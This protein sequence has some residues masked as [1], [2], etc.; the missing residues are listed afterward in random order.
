MSIMITGCAGFIG[1][2]AT[3]EFLSAGYDVIGVDSMTYAGKVENMS[4]FLSDISFFKDDICDTGR[5]KDIICSYDITT[6]INFAAHTHVDNSINSCD[7]FIYSNV[8]GVKSLLDA[9]R[10][11]DAELLQ[12]ST[13]EVYGSILSGSFDESSQMFPQNPY[14]ATKASAEHM[15]YAWANTYGTNHKIVRMSNCFGPRQHDEKFIPTILR[16][17]SSGE[18]VPVYGTGENIREWFYVKDCVSMLRSIHEKGASG[19]IYNLTMKNEMKNLEVIENICTLLG[20]DMSS[21]IEFVSDRLGHDYRYSMENK[22]V[23]GIHDKPQTP[24]EV[25]LRKTVASFSQRHNL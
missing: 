18:K 20:A 19:E 17:L 2:H 5:M 8:F 24:F 23:M 15:I 12:V 11:T 1:S 9:C 7:D 21:S 16:K 25:A 14:S 4:T 13:D 22:K 3:E 10:T 6:V